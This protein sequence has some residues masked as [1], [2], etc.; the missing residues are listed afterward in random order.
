[1]KMN[2]A[3]KTIFMAHLRSRKDGQTFKK[4]RGGET[5]QR[6]ADYPKNIKR[7][8]AWRFAWSNLYSVLSGT[9]AAE[10]PSR[11]QFS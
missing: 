7:N 6:V 2:D 8:S 5:A 1:M 11:D 9:M 3:K 10:T 4:G